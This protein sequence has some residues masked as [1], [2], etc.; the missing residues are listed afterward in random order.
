M[1]FKLI[2]LII[3]IAGAIRCTAAIFAY[4]TISL[5]PIIK[6]IHKQMSEKWSVWMNK[7]RSKSKKNN[8][9]KHKETTNK[10]NDT[11]LKMDDEQK[12][13]GK[14]EKTTGKTVQKGDDNSATT[15][16][17]TQITGWK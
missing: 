2:I 3:V 16:E 17:K 6:H 7:T 14:Q 8:N 10:K 15:I 11:P 4:V 5:E 12:G 1:Y 13:G 9:N